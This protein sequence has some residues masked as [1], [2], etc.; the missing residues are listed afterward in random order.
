VSAIR[1]TSPV[2]AVGKYAALAFYLIFA[3]FPLYWLLKV[4]VT[5]D[6]LLY[7]EGIRFVAVA[8]QLSSFSLRADP[9]RAFRPSSSTA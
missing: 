2:L 5:P 3:L 1:R 4:S 9:V 8:G 7:T 6:Q